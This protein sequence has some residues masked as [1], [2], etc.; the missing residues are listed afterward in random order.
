VSRLNAISLITQV[1]NLQAFWRVATKDPVS[2]DIVS[3]AL[4]SAIAILVLLAHPDKA[5]SLITSVLIL[6][7]RHHPKA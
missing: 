3:L 1:V 5:Q 7:P 2:R 4:D 6:A